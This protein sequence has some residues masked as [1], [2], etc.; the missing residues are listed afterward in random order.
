MRTTDQ[1]IETDG[2]GWYSYLPKLIHT[3]SIA[4]RGNFFVKLG[5]YSKFSLTRAHAAKAA[6]PNS[7]PKFQISSLSSKISLF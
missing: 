1:A 7:S 5:D 6:V 4:D 2:T 3:V